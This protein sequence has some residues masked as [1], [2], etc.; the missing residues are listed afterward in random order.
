MISNYRAKTGACQGD[1][2]GEGIRF[3][4]FCSEK[5]EVQGLKFKVD[6]ETP[7][8]PQDPEPEVRLV[9]YG[10][11]HQPRVAN[12]GGVLWI[13]PGHLRDRQDRGYPP[14]FALLRL[15]PG[16]IEVEIRRL[17]DGILILSGGQ[18][19]PPQT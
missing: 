16:G 18:A 4:V 9:L 6:T 17:Q 7:R 10:H 1:G 8:F 5:I 12:R 14:T 15:S 13:N 2:A 11:T 19:C 3:S